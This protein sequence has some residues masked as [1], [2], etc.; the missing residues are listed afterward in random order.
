MALIRAR[1]RWVEVIDARGDRRDVSQ[2]LVECPSM[3]VCGG[4]RRGKGLYQ[5]S[6]VPKTAGEI[7]VRVEDREHR[8]PVSAQSTESR[9]VID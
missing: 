5:V 2:V 7:V 6:S 4:V 8:V 1:T 9:V 3:R